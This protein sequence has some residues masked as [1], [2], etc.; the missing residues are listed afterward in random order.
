MPWGG[1]HNV[2]VGWAGPV[3]RLVVLA[4]T[5]QRRQFVGQ[6]GASG[7]RGSRRVVRGVEPQRRGTAGSPRGR[8]P[9]IRFLFVRAVVRLRLPSDPA[10]RRAPLPSAI[11][12]GATS[13]RLRLSLQ[14]QGM[15]G[16]RTGRPRP[17]AAVP[18]RLI[19]RL[20]SSRPRPLAAVPALLR[21]VVVRSSPSAQ[22]PRKPL[23]Y[24][25]HQVREVV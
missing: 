11:R 9:S 1:C 14:T 19:L 20:S 16:T 6:R 5:R 4:W 2:V 8:W 21:L 7:R 25:E 24:A 17:P 22:V 10:S 3:V 18:A 15:P 12:F 23:Y 13:V